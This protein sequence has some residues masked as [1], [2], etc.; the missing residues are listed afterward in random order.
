MYLTGD[1]RFII[2][3]LYP[4]HVQG[5]GSETEIAEGI[6]YFNNQGEAEVIILARGGGSIEDLWPFNEELLAR[7]I[8]AS[9][10]PIVSAVGHETDYTIA[11][12][13]ADK[14]APTP[15]AAAEIV[16]P[17]L[18]RLQEI[19]ENSKNRLDNSITGLLDIYKTRIDSLANRPVMKRPGEIFNLTEIA[20]DRLYE[21]MTTSISRTMERKIFEFKSLAVRMELLSPIA[22]LTRGYSVL[23]NDSGHVI[24]S[25]DNVE[26]GAEI[27][28][29]LQNGI[30]NCEVI[31][32]ERKDA[33][34]IL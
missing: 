18:I 7:A 29:I 2:Y 31:R 21:R 33:K 14:R 4:S 16:V 10:I 26:P 15:S 11:D 27:K 30:I 1:S 19:L 17:E 28:A 23:K 34:K 32:K 9:K 12:F 25:I 20:V 22:T 6:R 3:E 13:V 5:K 24:T 8:N